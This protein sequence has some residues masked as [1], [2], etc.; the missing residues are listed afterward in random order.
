MYSN[1]D[2]YSNIKPGSYFVLIFP[3]VLIRFV[4]VWGLPLAENLSR[5]TRGILKS[6]TPRSVGSL[7]NM[8]KIAMPSTKSVLLPTVWN[9]SLL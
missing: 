8:H 6:L 1:C 9:V 7:S 4:C 5:L 3:L 2:V